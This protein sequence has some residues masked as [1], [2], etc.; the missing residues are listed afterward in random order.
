MIDIL[1]LSDDYH[2]LAKEHCKN[3]EYELKEYYDLEATVVLEPRLILPRK[4]YDV[5]LID[6]G[7][8]GKDIETIERIYLKFNIAWTGALPGSMI[9]EDI[10][11]LYPDKTHLLVLPFADLDATDI[12]YCI[13]RI[14]DEEISQTEVI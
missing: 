10:R 4:K 9:K 7:L 2:D 14:I 12:S 5:V 13:W 6:Y 11:K 3:I 8:V 1:L